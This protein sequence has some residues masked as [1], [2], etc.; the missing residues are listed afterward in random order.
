MTDFLI[1]R[2]QI[3]DD[4]LNTFAYEILFRGKD[5][6]LS[7]Q[8]SAASATNQVITDTILEIGLNELVGPHLAF[9]NFT[10]QNILEK[11]PLHLPKDRIVVEVLENVKVDKQIVKNLRELSAQ[12]Y[13]IALDDFELTPEWLPLLEFVDIIKLDIIAFSLED[14]QQLIEKLKPYKLKL[15]AEKVET[16]QEFKLLR[17]WGCELFQ[18]FFFSK[19]NIVEGKRLGVSQITTLQLLAT[20]N[21]QDVTFLDVSKVIAQ[22]INLSYKLLRYINSASFALPNKIDSLQ[23]AATYLGLKEIRRWAN[24]LALSSMSSKPDAVLQTILVRAKMCE[25]LAFE[26]KQ[27]PEIYF[28]I[29]L[30][31]GLDS[32]LDM[33]LE[34]SLQQLPLSDQVCEAILQ[35]TGSAG[36]A[37]QYALDYERWDVNRPTFG[38]IKPKRIADIYLES[39]Q[40]WSRQV[41]P[42]I[43]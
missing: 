21:K 41:F 8:E 6:D 12:G 10:A 30:L 4:K 43:Q 40:W 5:F 33:P 18:G 27:D 34:K 2:Q 20:I 26:V 19:P 37:L 32:I 25:L 36:E 39:I 28:L 17:D 23:H 16:Y 1:G 31:S 3:L 35:K 38:G 13:T 22:D 9:I 29:G 7:I 24:I 11:T 14:T 42:Y 15:L